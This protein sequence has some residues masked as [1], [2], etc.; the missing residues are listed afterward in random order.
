MK[1][2]LECDVV[3]SYTKVEEITISCYGREYHFIPNEDGM[4]G[5][6]KIVATADH[7]EKFEMTFTPQTD[8]PESKNLNFS[9]DG[10]QVHDILISDFQYLEGIL[11]F[12]GNI[13]QINWQAAKFE[14]LPETEEENAR[15]AIPWYRLEKMSDTREVEIAGATIAQLILRR[16]FLGKLLNQFL[17]FFREGKNSFHAGRYINAFLNFYF[18]LEGAYGEEG[19][20]RNAETREDFL[21]SPEFCKFA[22]EI[23]ADN[24]KADSR[25]H[26]WIS[27]MLQNLKDPRG[28]PIPKPL[29]AEGIAWLLVDTRGS[30]LHFKKDFSDFDNVVR[31]D[32]DY[33]ALSLVSYELARKTLGHYYD[34]IEAQYMK[35]MEERKAKKQANNVSPE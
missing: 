31:V 25:Y 16:N 23:I 18:V 17:V 21:N 6:I 4:L 9:F 34:A 5:K 24:L 8:K 3:N 1:F 30:L 32:E 7:P 19:R 11:A 22:D 28:N 27:R 14:Y 2:S 35:I 13:G 26:W 12:L 33:E 29:N 20:W 15:I 10:D